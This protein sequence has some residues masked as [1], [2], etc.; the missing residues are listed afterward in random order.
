MKKKLNPYYC[1]NLDGYIL[2]HIHFPVYNYIFMKNTGYANWPNQ[3]HH[4]TMLLLQPKA[5]VCWRNWHWKSSMTVNKFSWSVFFFLSVQKKNLETQ[6][7]HSDEQW[8][9]ISL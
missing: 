5:I 1:T 3:L 9:H 2:F 4:L 7:Y 8:T 6:N